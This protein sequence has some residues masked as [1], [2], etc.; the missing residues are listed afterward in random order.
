MINQ[1]D[2]FDWKNLRSANSSVKLPEAIQTLAISDNDDELDDA[3]W[4]IDNESIVQGVLFQSS[5]AVVICLL[6]ILES[7]K[8]LARPYILELLVQFICGE[9]SQS[10]IEHGNDNLLANIRN[11]VLKYF[12]LFI[13]LAKNT[14]ESEKALCID[15]IGVCALEDSS[16]KPQVNE[17]LVCLKDRFEQDCVNE[18]VENWLAELV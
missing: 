5:L 2:N 10:E 3:Y 18:L 1:V 14:N 7:C 13:L 16:L 15:I 17:L 9:P 6:S 4:E 8:A 11:E 12:P